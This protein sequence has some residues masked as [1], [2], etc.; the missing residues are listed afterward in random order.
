M[1]VFNED[2]YTIDDVMQA[3]DRCAATEMQRAYQ[4]GDIGTG[5]DLGELSAMVGGMVRTHAQDA[6]NLSETQKGILKRWVA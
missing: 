2:R 5:D 1:S 4:C 3:I 6:T